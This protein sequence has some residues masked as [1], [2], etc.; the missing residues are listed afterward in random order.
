MKKN[1]FTILFLS[2][3]FSLLADAQIKISTIA[4]LQAMENDKSY[5]LDANID[6]S[7]LSAGLNKDLTNVTFDGNNYTLSN[8]TADGGDRGGL[9]KNLSGCTIRNLKIKDFLIGGN[10]VGTLAGHADNTTITKCIAEGIEVQAGGIAG[11]LIGHMEKTII[12]EC[13]VRGTVTGRDHVGGIAGHMQNA[14]TIENC[15]VNGDIVTTGWQV[16]GIVGWSEGANDKVNNCFASGTVSAAVGFTGGIIG[17]GVGAGVKVSNCLAIQTK[18]TANSDIPKTNRIV[19]DHNATTLENNYGLENMAWEDPKRTETWT[20]LNDGKDGTSVTL[21]QV[22][23]PQFYADSLPTWNFNTVWV[24]ENNLPKL[25]MENGPVSGIDEMKQGVSKVMNINSEIVVE[26]PLNSSIS[27]YNTI[28][29]LIEQRTSSTVKEIF[30]F[31]GIYMI[32][33]SSNAG[34]ETFKVIN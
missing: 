19:G 9:F 31:K 28:G 27:V 15:Y 10:W 32:R 29:K 8:L 23:S 26:C 2:V 11:G 16:G 3:A 20:N 5:I 18:I 12:T 30:T 1:L 4:G 25:K 14:S 24:L 34:N 6:L 22:A 21:A 13:A 7:S 33:I 17:A